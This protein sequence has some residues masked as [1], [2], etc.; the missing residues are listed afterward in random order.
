MSGWAADWRAAA[1]Q[2]QLQRADLTALSGRLID[3]SWLVWNEEHDEWF[4]DLPVVLNLDDGRQL[5]VSW[6]KFDELSI[7]WNTIDTQVSPRWPWPYWPLSWRRA[8]H[9]ALLANEGSRIIGV[10][11]TMHR[12]VT[13]QVEPPTGERAEVWLTSALWLQTT[14]P[15]LHIFNALD[16]NGLSDTA[17]ATSE[18]LRSSPL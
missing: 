13:T 7:T 18:D 2:L 14:G 4:A 11:A 12:F 15:G 3:S 17:P 5:E 6:Q 9:P 16:E 1:D 8:G 10:A